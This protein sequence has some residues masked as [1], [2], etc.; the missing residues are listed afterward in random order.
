MPPAEP[1][2]E[3][4]TFT[5][6]HRLKGAR[7]DYRTVFDAAPVPMLLCE[8][9]TLRVLA[10]NHAAAELHGAR[11]GQLEGTSLFELRHVSDLTSAMLKRAA[12]QPLTLGFG[13]HRRVD[14]SSFAAQLAVQPAELGAQPVWLCSLKSLEEALHPREGEQHRQLF[15]AIGRISGGVAHDINN[16]LSVVLS[17]SNLVGAQLPEGS[18]VREDL[19]EIRS[20]AERATALT[21]QL[22]GLSRKGPLSPKPVQLNELVRRME[23]LLRRLLDDRLGL[24]LKLEPDLDQVLADASQ[25]ER[26]LLQLAGEARAGSVKGGNLTIETRHAELDA[27]PGGGRQVVLCV[28]DTENSFTAETAGRASLADGASAWLE[29]D[30]ESGARFV[31]H[32]PSVTGPRNSALPPAT[33]PVA[34]PETVLVVQDNPHLRKTLKTYFAREGF[35]VLEAGTSGEAARLAEHA[36]RIDLVL[37]DFSLPDGSGPELGRALRSRFPRLKL[38]L[39][40]GHP[41]QRGALREDELTAVISKPF[42]L[43]QFGTVVLRLLDSSRH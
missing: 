39:A 21:K 28:H 1:D 17:F 32:F 43:Q 10:A 38:L 5:S 25:V 11:P 4:G 22:L 23:K 37:S 27:E 13:Y 9:G 42:D 31:A 33:S 26:L 7:D 36:A 40:I 14:G 41:E 16:L 29:N 24:V 35:Q 18:P 12:G 30:P 20:A 34:R 8:V 3:P 6:Q 15:D 19:A 2:P